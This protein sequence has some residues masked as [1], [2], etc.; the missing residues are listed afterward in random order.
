[1][2][3]TANTADGAAAKKHVIYVKKPSIS[4][5]W[6][7]T[8]EDSVIYLHFLIDENGWHAGEGTNGTGNRAH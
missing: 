3:N 1:M 2:H 6:H 5:S 8:G 4:V 7:F